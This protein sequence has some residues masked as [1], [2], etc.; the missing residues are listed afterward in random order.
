[1]LKKILK[2]NKTSIIIFTICILIVIISLI[3][4]HYYKKQ[5]SEGL[6]EK[7]ENYTTVIANNEEKSGKFVYIKI[8]DVPYL[9]AVETIDNSTNEYYVVYDENNYMYIVQLKKST[10]QTICDE[11]DKNPNDFSYVV[12]GRL[13]SVSNDLEDIIIDEFN[14][15]YEELNLNRFNYNRYFGT[16]YLNEKAL[17]PYGVTIAISELCC[18]VSGII[19]ILYFIIIIKEYINIRKSLKHINKEDLKNELSQPEV[20]EYPKAKILLLDRYFVSMDIGMIANEYSDIAWVYISHNTKTK[21]GTY[22]YSITN[23]SNMM[24]YLKNGK[25][26]TTASVKDKENEI[27]SEI[28]EELIKKNP[29]ILVGYSYE[30]LNNYNIIKKQS[31]E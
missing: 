18:I 27:Y 11:Y 28:I 26:Y 14:E 13:A 12:S 2:Y 4:T 6:L 8:V 5:K 1:M 24:V 25:K 7:A 29:N 19:A 23:R 3:T 30:N 16:T 31:I 17:T 15:S 9:I 20:I 22:H 21:W 10:Y